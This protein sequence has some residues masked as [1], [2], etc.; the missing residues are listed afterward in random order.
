MV[1]VRTLNGR[2]LRFGHR[3]W[4][5]RNAYL[6]Y[7]IETDSIWHHQTGWAMSGEL[8]G[9]SLRRFPTTQSTFSAWVRAHPRTRVLPKPAQHDG[10]LNVD[11]YAGRNA[12]LAFGLGVDLPEAYRL[13]PY[14]AV[15]DVGGLVQ[16]EIDGLAIVVA[17]A[18][19]ERAAVGFERRVD[20]TDVD[21]QLDRSDAAGPLLREVAGNRA[22]HLLSGLPLQGSGTARS[23]RPLLASPWESVA[24]ERQHPSGTVW[25]PPGKDAPVPDR[26][27]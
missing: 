7:D 24:W 4:L 3:G 18:P 21:F 1:H 17:V 22:W 23:L 26:G 13:Y 5:W 8:R 6:L 12:G 2:S 9:E 19:D 15:A 14:Q 10:N 16:D 20:G 27:R 25:T 11:V